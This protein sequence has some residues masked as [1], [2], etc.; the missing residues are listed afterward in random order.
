MNYKTM[1][2]TIV[3]VNTELYHI[4]MAFNA[5]EINTFLKFKKIT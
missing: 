4:D 3:W 5:D 2:H 1:C